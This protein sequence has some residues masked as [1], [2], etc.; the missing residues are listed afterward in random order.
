MFKQRLFIFLVMLMSLK[1]TLFANEVNLY[2]DGVKLEGGTPISLR[3]TT[4]IPIGILARELDLRVEWNNP[5][6]EISNNIECIQFNL[7]DVNAY[8]DQEIFFLR[9]APFLHEDRVYVPLRAVSELFGY[10]VKFFDAD[11]RI[12]V[13]TDLVVPPV[14]NEKIEFEMSPDGKW[15]IWSEINFYNN[16]QYKSLYL[17]SFTTGKSYK[18]HTTHGFYTAHWTPESKII[19]SGLNEEDKAFVHLFDPEQM[20]IIESIQTRVYDYDKHTN[21]LYYYHNNQ[22]IAYDLNKRVQTEISRD[23]YIRATENL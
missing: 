7:D 13:Q 20:K 18:L 3:N 21:I 5:C 6:V 16:H 4:F 10:S 2:V 22:Y 11:K 15:G 8:K 9:E 19:F 17:R 12:E 1:G 14:K 23:E